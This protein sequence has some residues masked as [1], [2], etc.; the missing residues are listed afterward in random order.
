MNTLNDL[1]K[2][3]QKQQASLNSLTGLGLVSQLVQS[4]QQRNDILN[5]SSV[6]AIS[7]MASQ[8]TKQYEIPSAATL[9]MTSG[10][11]A[12]LKANQANQFALKSLTSSLNELYKFRP[13]V[14]NSL[15][16]ITSS[17]LLR[18]SALDQI[19]K[20][21]QNSHLNKFNSLSHVISGIS[22]S[23][24]TEISKQKSWDDLIIIDEANQTIAEVTED[25]F[26]DSEVIT[27]EDLEQFKTELLSHISILISKSSSEKIK[28]FLFDLMT[29][30][31]FIITVYTFSQQGNETPREDAAELTK[32]EILKI[33]NELNETIALEFDKLQHKRIATTNVNLRY[34]AKKRS[35][36]IGLVEIG[37]EVTV[38][39]IHHKWILVAYIDSRTEEP[40]SGFVYKKYFERIN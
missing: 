29:V 5:L 39:E 18:T 7:N 9:A 38:L 11:H 13:E 10:M 15:A 2:S 37:Q 17:S 40:K 33:K 12:A 36:I 26:S 23:Y 14:S 8:L 22:N 4:V 19:A 1:L 24:L 20:S 16:A 21:V 30:I 31:G 27:K 32:Q 3:I 34:S 35:E 28:I 6:N 25:L